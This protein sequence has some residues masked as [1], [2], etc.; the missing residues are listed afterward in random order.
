[1]ELKLYLYTQVVGKGRMCPAHTTVVSQ[2]PWLWEGAGGGGTKVLRSG[3]L[4]PA[5]V[6][7]LFG[8]AQ[9]SLCSQ[10]DTFPGRHV[11]LLEQTRCC[12]LGRWENVAESPAAC[13][14]FGP[15]HSPRLHPKGKTSFQALCLRGVAPPA[16]CIGALRLLAAGAMGMGGPVLR[17]GC[18]RPWQSHPW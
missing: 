17:P 2:G 14:R 1:M 9:S 12:L 18:A 13:C 3:D 7:R 11:Q 10:P 15:L 5:G 16:R 4:Q 8:E 6:Q